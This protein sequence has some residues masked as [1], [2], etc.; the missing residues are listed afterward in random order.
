MIP[1]L[2]NF[3]LFLAI[4]LAVMQIIFPLKGAINGNPGYL[5]LGRYT[6]WGQFILITISIS[7]LGYAFLT[8]DFSVA[9]VAENSNSHLPAVY[10]F[11]AIWGAHEGSILLWV[12]ILTAWMAAVSSF[13]RS[14]PAP[15]CARVLAVL[16]IIALGFYLFLI[17]T[18]SPF[19]RLL[20]NVP[21]DGADLNPILQDPGLAV[22]PPILYMGYVGFAVP[23]AF[24]MAALL[25]KELDPRW[26]RWSRPWTLVA[27]CFLTLGIVLGSAWAYHELGWGGWWFWD[28]VEN[29]SFLPWLAGTALIHSLAVTEKRQIFKAWTVLLA[30]CAFSLSL[31]GTFLV[32]SGV[33]VSVHSFASDPARGLFM[34]VFLLL[35]VGGSLSLYA[36]RGRLLATTGEFSLLSRESMLLLNNLLLFVAML[37]VLLGTLYP[38]VLSTLNLEKIS[39]GPPYFNSVFIPIFSP[40]LFLM[41]IAPIFQ[42]KQTKFSE[43][44]NKLIFFFILVALL[45]VI[46]C[47]WIGVKM[48]LGF[49]VALMLA[50][51]LISWTLSH[52]FRWQMKP[53]IKK[54]TSGQWAMI[55]AHIGVGVTTLGIICTTVCSQQRDIGMKPG[56][57]LQ[58]G[59]YQ[60]H[61]INVTDVQGPNYQAIQAEVEIYK[62]NKLEKILFPEQRYFPV[63]R[64][65]TTKAAIDAG[66]FRD[67]YV[68]LGSSLPGGSWSFR[69][70]Y[71]PF[72]RWIWA[73]GVMMF[74]GGLLGAADRRYRVRVKSSYGENHGIE[75]ETS[76]VNLGGM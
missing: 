60:F 1:E 26:V 74:F 61:F 36:W 33:L 23:F 54:M 25:S 30:V 73:G 76:N 29:A 27:W 41:A 4:A 32:R 20:P 49:L 6:A 9:Y 70:Y 47:W 42:W 7:T 5:L 64:S 58:M 18:S 12:F 16:A 38:L 2:G 14:I 63:E 34:L 52:G 40:A 53:R 75:S 59:A 71:K 67:L 37:T 56:D 8:N 68:A 48:T 17:T 50:I 21:A 13:S 46:L 44:R 66:V 69:I 57:S 24:A 51:W 22:H 55:L 62:H 10:R 35:V 19:V 31:L 28:P 15:V 72:V 3:C 43:I 65:T 45:S 11:C 39:V